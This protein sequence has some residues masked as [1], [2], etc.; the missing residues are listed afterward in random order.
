MRNLFA[1]TLMLLV[2]TF[3]ATA[4]EVSK[5]DVFGG[6]Q[7]GHIDAFG[8]QRVN[9]NGWNG[10]FTRYFSRNFGLTGDVAGIYGTPN[11]GGF[12]SKITM[13]SFMSGPTLRISL[14]RSTPFVHSLFGAMKANVDD[15]ALSATSFVWALGG[16]LDYDVNRSIAVRAVQF[17]YMGTKFNYAPGS[18]GQ[19]NFRYSGGVVFKF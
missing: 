12:P 19:N 16:G 6:Y 17:D 9:L 18:D 2:L 10:Q 8:I 3:T 4:Q 5:V 7:F 15:G 1:I 13:Y 11:V 14:A